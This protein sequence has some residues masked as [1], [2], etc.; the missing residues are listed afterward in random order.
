MSHIRTLLLC[1]FYRQMYQLVAG[2][3]VYVAQP[4][5]FR[6]VRG[7]KAKYYVQTEEEMKFQLMEKG[8]S[9]SRFVGEPVKSSKDRKC[10]SFVRRSRI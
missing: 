4:P 10:E 5:L 2:G 3:H 7:K 1:F 6:V 9:D 8:L